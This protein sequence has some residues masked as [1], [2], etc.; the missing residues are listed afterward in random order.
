M[1][2]DVRPPVVKADDAD[3]ELS[4]SA[5]AK[6]KSRQG[7]MGDTVTGV[8]TQRVACLLGVYHTVDHAIHTT[9]HETRFIP[10]FD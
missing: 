6:K 9:V 4:V 2:L 8:L 7:G 5:T 10:L 3:D 1:L